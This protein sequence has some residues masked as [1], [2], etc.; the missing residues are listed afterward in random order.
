VQQ[1]LF[2]CDEVLHMNVD[3]L[4][5]SSGCAGVNS[6]KFNTMMRI[7]HFWCNARE[8][9]R[10]G[11]NFFKRSDEGHTFVDGKTQMISAKG[12]SERKT[13]APGWTGR[14]KIRGT[15]A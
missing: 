7:A 15:I 2:L 4:V 9:R 1:E 10:A 12:S 3:N 13:F 8:S 11:G 14:E 6:A 5:E